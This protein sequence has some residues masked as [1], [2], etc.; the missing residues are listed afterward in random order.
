MHQSNDQFIKSVENLQH[1]SSLIIEN[2]HKR[3]NFIFSR[4]LMNVPPYKNYGSMAN[5]LMN[6]HEQ[7]GA[8]RLREVEYELFSLQEGAE[9]LAEG[10][11][12]GED[13][14][15]SI[16]DGGDLNGNDDLEQG[17]NRLNGGAFIENIEEEDEYSD[18]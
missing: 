9:E 10:E 15:E 11:G 12:E 8:V 17:Q 7:I 6:L 2:V 18:G 1:N 14:T 3:Q 4:H 13:A 16:V 5:L